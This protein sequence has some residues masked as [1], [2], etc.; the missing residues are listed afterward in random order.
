G[1]RPLVS[2]AR[3][4]SLR[5]RLQGIFAE[6]NA[7]SRP[8]ELVVQPQGRGPRE[9]PLRSAGPGPVIDRKGSSVP[10]PFLT[11]AFAGVGH[12]PYSR[13]TSCSR[14]R[15]HCSQQRRH[16]DGELLPSR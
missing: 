4:S 13:T 1:V 8:D 7:A 11:P 15:K 6:L 16:F 14:T 5:L 9:G 10:T 3:S 12:P 2:L